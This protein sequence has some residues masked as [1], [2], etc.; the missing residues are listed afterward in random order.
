MITVVHLDGLSGINYHRLIVPLLR[1]R[2]QGLDG[3]CFIQSLTELKDM[4]L[5]KV[6]NLL[7]SRKLSVTNHKEFKKMLV[8]HNVRLILDNDDYWKLNR[9]NPAWGLYEVYYGPDIKK[10]IRI[11]DVIWTPSKYLARQMGHLNPLADIQ[12]VNN[13]VNPDEKQ[14]NNQR[15]TSGKELRFGY[16]GAAAHINDLKLMGYKFTGKNL[17]CIKDLGYEEI[18]DPNQTLKPKGIFEYGSYYKRIDVSLAPLSKNKFNRCKSDLKVTEAAMT[19][20]AIIAS[21][22]DNYNGSII[23]GETGLLCAT[24][25]QWKEAI[26]SM[27]KERAKQLGRNLYDSLV[28]DP[29]HNL[30]T[31]NQT[32]LNYLS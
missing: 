18:L 2:E 17:T 9:D 23:H 16:L 14:W 11:A 26:E 1:L 13:A 8:E 15:K 3:L 7:I 6:D 27:T 29:N 20:T 4:D 32:R 24:T 21:D 31:I 25:D 5:D 19:K 22:I 12:F 10:T 28:D 30:D